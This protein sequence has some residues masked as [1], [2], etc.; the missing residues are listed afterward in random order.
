MPMLVLFSK[1]ILLD[2]AEMPL[3]VTNAAAARQCGESEGGGSPTD[4]FV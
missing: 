4:R 1:L 3:F 2:L